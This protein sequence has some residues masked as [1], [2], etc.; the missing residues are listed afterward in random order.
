MR[1]CILK[2]DCAEEIRW[3]QTKFEQLG[4]QSGLL[5]KQ[6]VDRLVFEKMNGRCP[7]KDSEI[8]KIRYWRTGRHKPQNREQCL[9]FARALELN[10]EET[11]YLLQFYYDSADRIFNENDE[12]DPLYQKRL[13]VMQQLETQYLAN[14]HP[15]QLSRLDISWEKPFPSLR[16]Y[17]FQDVKN[18]IS[19][20]KTEKSGSRFS[21]TNYVHEFQKSRR[22]LGE[23]PRKTMLRHLFVMGAPFL[24][25]S[26]MNERL[27]ALGYAPLTVDHETRWGER[28]D[29]LI[30][31]LLGYY[32]SECSG[33]SPSE[34]LAWLQ[35]TCREL[36]E[37][38]VEKGH[39]ELR[40]LYFKALK[41][42]E[43]EKN[44]K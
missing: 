17:Y 5:R 40:F 21:S 27:T 9:E 7:E 12:E 11:N 36:D 31:R 25:V 20:E 32:E 38:L 15:D 19:S 18:Y 23:I 24:S 33:K 29:C 10:A 44:G 34:G 39:R 42:A 8:L 3:V 43:S 37:E 22:L 16:H 1:E 14:A 2:T 35:K 41:N 4:K 26:V 13:S 28:L 30:I 6:D